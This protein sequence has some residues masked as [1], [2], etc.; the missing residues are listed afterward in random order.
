MKKQIRRRIKA[1]NGPDIS[2]A[3]ADR[4]F[5]VSICLLSD[6]YAAL[7]SSEGLEAEIKDWEITLFIHGG[8]QSSVDNTAVDLPVFQLVF[9]Q[10][11]LTT[12]TFSNQDNITPS[13]QISEMLDVACS[14][15]YAYELAGEPFSYSLNGVAD[16][17][18]EVSFNLKR[19]I[20]IP[21][22]IIETMI[23]EESLRP[24]NINYY[25]LILTGHQN[26]AMDMDIALYEKIDFLVKPRPPQYIR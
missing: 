20:K 14:N 13:Y 2:P 18:N 10:H 16:G 19:T 22:R 24:D 3:A 11:D 21:K 12:T 25:R 23:S 17:E 26:L 15:K 7:T 1:W 5:A 8:I 9:L 6:S 4:A